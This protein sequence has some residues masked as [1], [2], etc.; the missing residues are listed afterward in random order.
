MKVGLVGYAGSGKSTVFEWLTGQKPDPG[1]IQQGQ[2]AMADVPDERLRK[3][4]EIYKPKKTTFAKI[5]F[6][7][8][9]GLMMD[10][11]KDNPRRLGILRE[12]N[13]IV[14]VLDGFSRTD[15]AN[16]LTKFREDMLY[17]DLEVVSNRVP[18]VEAQFRKAKPQKEREVDEFELATLK[19]VIALF[20]AGKPASQMHITPEEEKHLRSFQLLTLKPETAFVNRGDSGFNDP[21]PADLLALAPA[22]CQAP[23]KLEMELAALDAESRQMFMEEMGFKESFRDPT[24]RAIFYAMGRIA[25]FTVGPDECRT[26]AMDTGGDAVAAANCIHKELGERFVRANVISH[27]DFVACDY[28]E[29][30]AKSRGV[31]RTEGKT[32]IVQDADI[33]HILASA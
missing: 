14:V 20:E 19:R 21:L 22:A 27:A 28:S 9:P 17:A 13:G 25:F 11:R 1:K 10:D 18:K 7:D 5:E 30:E 4:S 16:Q 29:K 6:L 8:T 32:Y 2:V 31:N 23:V 15:F 26:W 3:I 24:I 12:A 33:L